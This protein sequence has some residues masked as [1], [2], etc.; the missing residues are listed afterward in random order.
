MFEKRSTK[1]DSE[2]GSKYPHCLPQNEN[3]LY[4]LDI[5]QKLVSGILLLGNNIAMLGIPRRHNIKNAGF[6][7]A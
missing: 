1:E 6:G 2:K 3:P 4:L 7:G 5:N